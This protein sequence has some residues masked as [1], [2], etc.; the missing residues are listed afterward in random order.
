MFASMSLSL[1]THILIFVLSLL[2]CYLQFSDGV[3]YAW[4]NTLK[5]H[6][7]K[8]ISD[9]DFAKRAETWPEDTPPTKEAIYYRRIFDELFKNKSAAQTVQRWVPKWSTSTDPSG[10]VQAVHTQKIDA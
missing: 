4:I 3:G 2:L 8:E 9:A 1:L 6:T 7:E 10:R 5:S